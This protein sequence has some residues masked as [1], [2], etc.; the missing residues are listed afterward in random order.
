MTSKDYLEQI[1]LIEKRI[2]LL[3]EK[4]NSI[5]SSFYGRVFRTASFIGKGCEENSA[6]E[7]IFKQILL[8]QE[9]LEKEIK[10][11]LKCRME[12]EDSINSVISDPFIKE[13][14]ERRYLLLQTWDE[15]SEKMNYSVSQLHRLHNAYLRD[16]SKIAA[17]AYTY[18]Y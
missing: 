3:E 5:Y 12:I 6:G 1:K 10:N 16:F 8:Y 4:Y 9:N 15:I 2:R 7:N 13:I 14:F 18:S 11:L 17:K